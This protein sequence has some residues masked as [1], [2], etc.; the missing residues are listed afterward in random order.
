MSSKQEQE[1]PRPLEISHE[2]N[3]PQKSTEKSQEVNP[4]NSKHQK[5]AE[6]H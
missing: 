5:S 4:T 2:K 1:F 6:M 3:N